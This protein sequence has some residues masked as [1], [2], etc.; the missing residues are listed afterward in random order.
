MYSLRTI[1]RGVKCFFNA[2][3]TRIFRLSLLSVHIT[4]FAILFPGKNTSEISV[5][6]KK[7]KKKLIP[8]SCYIPT[9]VEMLITAGTQADEDY[10]SMC[11]H[12]HCSRGKVKTDTRT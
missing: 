10:F 5:A 4:E 11:L 9:Q 3:F 2:L 1:S 7:K 12:S 6:K 8:C